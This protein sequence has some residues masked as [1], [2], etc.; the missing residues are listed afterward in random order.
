[1]EVAWSPNDDDKFYLFGTDLSL[2]GIHREDNE[3]G[4]RHS[5]NGLFLC[6]YTA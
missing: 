2:Y 6:D 5:H 1:M 3:E 4:E